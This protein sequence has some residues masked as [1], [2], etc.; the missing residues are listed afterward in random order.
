MDLNHGLNTAGVVFEK[1]EDE[2]PNFVITDYDL[3]LLKLVNEFRL[4]TTYQLSRFVKQKESNIYL[5]RRL[6]TLWLNKVFERFKVYQ[7]SLAG[8]P[9]YYVLGS[10]G[11]NLL[12]QLPDY[13]NDKIKGHKHSTR[14]INWQ[15][16][17]HNSMLTEIASHEAMLNSQDSV[18]VMFKG[19]LGSIVYDEDHPKRFELIAPDFMSLYV[20]GKHGF[21]IYSEFERTYKANAKKKKKIKNYQDYLE[22]REGKHYV[23]FIFPTEKMELGYWTHL[24][25]NEPSLIKSLNLVSTNLET[26]QNGESFADKIYMKVDPKDLAI[27]SLGSVEK[28]HEGSF[29]RVALV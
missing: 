9:Y 29:E 27:R 23:R 1:R 18:K 7:G 4:A 6:K 3:K 14:I 22:G 25:K 12:K 8:M 13:D 28:V 15:N 2:A 10:A 5:Y 24:L 16:F 19:E 20:S 11:I 17:M 26:I 21:V